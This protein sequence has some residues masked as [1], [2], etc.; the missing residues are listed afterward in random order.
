MDGNREQAGGFQLQ[1][2]NRAIFCCVILSPI[3]MQ[4]G[5]ALGVQQAPAACR[6]FPSKNYGFSLKKSQVLS[7]HL[8]LNGPGQDDR[9]VNCWFQQEP[10]SHRCS[11]D[12]LKL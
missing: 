11:P 6:G 4:K 9:I 3:S 10:A 2:H 12:S 5:E 8:A 1:P 7:A